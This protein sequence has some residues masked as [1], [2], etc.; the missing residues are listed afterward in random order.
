MNTTPI[1]KTPDG[2]QVI[3]DIY[4]SILD[5]WPVP[6]CGLTQSTRH[7]ETFI[8]ASGEETAPSVFLLHGSTSNAT[9]W[10]AD[11]A[12]LSR[13]FR[14]YAVD[15]P[16]EPGHSSHNRPSWN[17]PDLAEWMTD[18]LDG[19]HLKKA[20]LLGISQG[21]FTA[22]KFAT[23]APHRV[24]KLVLLAPGGIQQPRASFL[25]QAIPLSFLGRWGA[26]RINR[27]TFGK[28]PV[29]REAVEIMNV[30][31][32]H[33]NPRIEA[34]PIFT[35]TEL[36]R[37]TMPVLMIGGAQDAL[38]PTQ[39]IARRLEKNLPNVATLI[40]PDKGHVLVNLAKYYL[41]FLMDA[42]KN[43]EKHTL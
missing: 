40:L 17:G 10:I 28:E 37:L 6:Y 31:M 13:H 18:I 23:S 39:Q 43:T 41:P 35:D 30:I 27:I 29:S 15:I 12:D 33:F 20:S 26:E 7:G 25:L 1:Y 3:M 36:A 4:Q 21:G 34:Q 14:V 42:E 32:T 16:G 11:V 19:M 22:L 38:L 8:I 9:A 5:R 2:E 24:D